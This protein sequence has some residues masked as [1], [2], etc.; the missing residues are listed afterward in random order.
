MASAAGKRLMTF[1]QTG[2]I[3]LCV[4]VPG[5][6]QTPEIDKA[7]DELRQRPP[8]SPDSFDFVV[9]G[10]TRSGVPVDLPE[11]FKQSIREFNILRPAFVVD[12]GDL[13]LGGAVEGITPQWDEFERV[14][15]R[16]EVPFFP[17]TG[18]HDI[19]DEAT[20]RV[21][22]QR[23]GPVRYAFRY[24]NSYFIM[25]NSEEVGALDRIPDE[26]VA[27]LEKELASTDAKHVFLFLHQPYFEYAGDDAAA[28]ESWARRWANVAEVL[29]GHPVKVVFGAHS[30]IYRDCGVRD[31]VHHVITGGGGAPTGTPD[32]EGGFFHYLLVRVRGDEVTWAVVKPGSVLPG[33]AVTSERIT[34]LHKIRNKWVACESLVAPYGEGFDRDVTVTITNPFDQSFDSAITWEAPAGWSVAPNEKPYTVPANG[35]VDVTFRVKADSVESVRFPVPR[36]RTRYVNTKYG[37]PADVSVSVPLTPKTNAVHAPGPIAVDGDMSE[38]AEAKPVPLTYASGFDSRN[39]ADLQSQIRFMWDESNLYLAVETVDDE[40]CQPYA[41][42]IVWSADNVEL[43]LDDWAWGL[44]LTNAG[45]EVFLYEGVDVSAE[46][47]NTDVKLGIKRDGS[48][49]V[50]EAAFPASMVKPLELKAGASFGVAVGMNDLDSKVPRHSLALTPGGDSGPR[51]KVVL[52]K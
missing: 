15:G 44:T 47:V 2:V 31:G 10:D 19:S 13:I 37:P 41:G 21:W 12:I 27:W 40:Y 30:H 14:I 11:V 23:M 34:E 17:V 16:C 50:Y 51:V 46:M 6:T 43:S 8:V 33:D 9:F 18:N 22:L 32:E 42:D 29:H 4:C 1:V 7:L 49:M 39:T 20:E 36:F 24:G 52:E 45:P 25:L 35:A 28:A 38:W 26:Q 3:L 5:W 48:L